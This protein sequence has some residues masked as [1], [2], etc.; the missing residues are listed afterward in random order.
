MLVDSDQ[1]GFTNDVD[2]DDSNPDIYPGAVDIPDNGIDE[3]CDG[4]DETLSSTTNLKNFIPQYYPNPTTGII[5]VEIEGSFA[6][7]LELIDVHG[8]RLDSW[9]DIKGNTSL[10]LNKYPNGVYVVRFT[11]H[12]SKKSYIK[13]IFKI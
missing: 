11:T 6:Y 5:S 2:C 10:D 13:K 7:T 8:K 4:E 9:S 1:D 12:S 3:D